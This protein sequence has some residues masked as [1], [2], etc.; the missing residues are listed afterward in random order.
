[1]SGPF[2][3]LR[4][5]LVFLIAAACHDFQGTVR[6]GRCSA[7]ASSHGARVHTS[8]SSSELR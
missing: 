5:R 4:C 2:L 6:H 7:F 1:M 8:R 3:L